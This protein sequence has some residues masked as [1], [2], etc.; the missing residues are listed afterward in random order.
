MDRLDRGLNLVQ[1]GYKSD[2][3]GCDHHRARPSDHSCHL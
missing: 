2:Y 3:N 1:D